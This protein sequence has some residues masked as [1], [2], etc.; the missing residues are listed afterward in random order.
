MIC[1]WENNLHSWIDFLDKIRNTFTTHGSVIVAGL[2]E[3]VHGNRVPTG[4]SHKA[5]FAYGEFEAR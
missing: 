2:T 4:K 1:K 5:N 3:A